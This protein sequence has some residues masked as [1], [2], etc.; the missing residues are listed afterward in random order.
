[1][2]GAFGPSEGV[3][4]LRVLGTVELTGAGGVVEANR[5]ARLTEYLAYLV[6]TDDAITASSID[7]A[8]WPNRK[9]EN[10]ATTRDPA[11]SR[12]RK[13]LGTKDDGQLRLDLNTFELSGVDCDWHQ[14][15]AATRGTLSTIASEQLAGAISLVRGTP[16]KVAV[17]TPTT[18]GPNPS[19]SG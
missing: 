17:K 15:E 13:W 9:K 19:S 7:E 18:H 10:N 6:L 16:L 3:P 12:L 2:T 4:F 8:I 11:T 1:M 14:F 5:T